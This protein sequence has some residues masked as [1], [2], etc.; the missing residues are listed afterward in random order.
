M[1]LQALILFMQKH[2]R[3]LPPWMKHT[4]SGIAVP[5]GAAECTP[6]SVAG[7]FSRGCH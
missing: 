4:S 1:G 6:S 5:L 3:K 2:N 7:W